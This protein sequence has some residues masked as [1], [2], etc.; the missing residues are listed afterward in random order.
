M[1]KVCVLDY[2]IGNLKSL[3]N[4]FKILD[5][6]PVLT[7]N[8]KKIKDSDFLVLPG[9]G[10]FANAMEKLKKIHLDEAIYHFIDQGK[11]FMGICLGMQ[12]LFDFS[13][14]FGVTDGLGLIKG[15]VIKIP[16]KNKQIRLPNIG[17]NKIIKSNI[18]LSSNSILKNIRPEDYVYFIHSYCCKPKTDENVIA[19]TVYE[20]VKLC[21]SVQKNNIVG[22]Q[23]HPE[24]SGKVGFEILKNFIKN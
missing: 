14:E 9:V 22:L 18:E 23:F 6:T 1:K 13:E 3:Y 7:N 24:K 19:N 2:G 20:G 11:P 8:H 10:A 12:M 21:A 5:T 15:N 17:W 16:S 4:A